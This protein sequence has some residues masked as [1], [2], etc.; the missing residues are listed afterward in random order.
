MRSDPHSAPAKGK[1][2]RRSTDH[3]ED[4]VA[5]VLMSLGLVL[6][7]IAVMTG[8]GTRAGVIERAEAVRTTHTEVVATLLAD[9][10]V[11]PTPDGAAARQLWARA[12]WVG[13]DGA[14]RE[15]MVLVRAGAPVGTAVTVWVDRE[16]RIGPIPTSNTE[17]LLA[18]MLTGI[19]TLLVGGFVLCGIW[20]AARRV[21]LACNIRRWER[22]WARIGPEWTLHP[23]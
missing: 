10:P 18:G 16:G 20:V 11:L 1:M 5:W 17:A 14:H 8:V 19:F 7:L 3:F 6:L 9:A 22:E 4:A 15:D 12:G 23:R 21:T 2:P 13:T